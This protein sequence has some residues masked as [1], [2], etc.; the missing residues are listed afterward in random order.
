M[1]SR[2]ASCSVALLL[3]DWRNKTGESE[4]VSNLKI[5]R[6]RRNVFVGLGFSLLSWNPARKQPLALSRYTVVF[7]LGPQEFNTLRAE[8]RESLPL[9]LGL[10]RREINDSGFLGEIDVVYPDLDGFAYSGSCAHH[11]TDEGFLFRVA[12]DEDFSNLGSR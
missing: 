10:P 9:G 12:V 4:H 5:G 8:E 3:S 1:R 2:L 6:G 7:N 11:E